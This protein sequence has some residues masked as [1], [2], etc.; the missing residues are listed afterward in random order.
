MEKK[1]LTLPPS[2]NE[3]KKLNIIF[4][5]S[6]PS[7]DIYFNGLQILETEIKKRYSETS[8]VEIY[9]NNII[10]NKISQ[11]PY[12]NQI[13]TFLAGTDEER[14]TCLI[15]AFT[16]NEK[17]IICCGRG[18]Y[19]AI[20]LFPY[21]KKKELMDQIVQGLDKH[22]FIGFSDATF[23]H[24]V[25]RIEY[26]KY[27]PGK[28]L[29]TIHGPM[30]CTS[31]FS[32]IKRQND[33]NLTFNAMIETELNLAFPIIK[34]KVLCSNKEKKT[35][36]LVG[37]SLTCLL[38]CEGTEWALERDEKNIILFLEDINE[39]PYR[40][41]RFISQLRN[42]GVLDKCIGII[43]G[44]F[45]ITND[46]VFDS[47]KSIDD[48]DNNNNIFSRDFTSEGNFWRVVCGFKQLNIPIL[49][50]ADI[51]HGNEN[52]FPLALGANYTIDCTNMEEMD[53]TLEISM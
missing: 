22:R 6:A 14:I 4:P 26:K 3:C 38:A 21:F 28:N 51:G 49:Y 39:M 7:K 24:Q 30:P 15:N 46:T 44:D 42:V 47:R 40:L 10:A 52:N 50:H 33:I 35:G 43:L 29:I 18:G 41:D 45:S 19:G 13:F 27:Y 23:L 5:S 25:F 31:F 11:H 12:T 36:R 1:I 16:T 2:L 8:D 17:S 9:V 20:R 48:D 34:G 32:P 37:G 53:G